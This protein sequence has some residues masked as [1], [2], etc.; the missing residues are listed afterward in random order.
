MK[1]VTYETGG[2][3][4]AGVLTDDGVIDAG[5]ATM[6]ELLRAGEPAR[7]T[8]DRCSPTACWQDFRR[9]R[10][11]VGSLRDPGVWLAAGDE[12]VVES[13]TLGRLVTTLA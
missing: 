10:P 11:G 9:R 5:Y 13:P 12:V 6:R 3:T 4:R 1:L 8:G 2:Q 7:P